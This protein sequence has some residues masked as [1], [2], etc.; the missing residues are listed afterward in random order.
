MP[1]AQEHSSKGHRGVQSEIS[2]EKKHE[3]VRRCIKALSG[4]QLLFDIWFHKAPCFHSPPAP[5]LIFST[6]RF[7]GVTVTHEYECML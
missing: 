3:W 1:H 2:H 7:R 4:L 6:G 5:P